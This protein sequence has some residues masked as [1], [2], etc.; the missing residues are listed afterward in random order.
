MPKHRATAS[1]ASPRRRCSRAAAMSSAKTG[2]GVP[3]RQ[4]VDDTTVHQGQ[5]AAAPPPFASSR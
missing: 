3:V 2:P 4:R 1:A 5:S